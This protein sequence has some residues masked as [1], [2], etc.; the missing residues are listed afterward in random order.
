VT[1]PLN[2]SKQFV[3]NTLRLERFQVSRIEEKGWVPRYAARSIHYKVATNVL[4]E[5]GSYQQADI[6]PNSVGMLFISLFPEHCDKIF[7]EAVVEG[8]VCRFDVTQCLNLLDPVIVDTQLQHD[9]LPNCPLYAAY[10]SQGMRYVKTREDGTQYFDFVSVDNFGM[11]TLNAGMDALEIRDLLTNQSLPLN[12]KD[13]RFKLNPCAKL[14]NLLLTQRVEVW[15]SEQVEQALESITLLTQK[16]TL[17]P[18]GVVFFIYS[19]GVSRP[20]PNY[21]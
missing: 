13:P 11:F 3:I 17:S 21:A 14:E 15:R 7:F 8:A 20:R 2:P 4:Y 12:F 5:D 9:P 10:L 16:P 1:T 6:P 18:E 19:W